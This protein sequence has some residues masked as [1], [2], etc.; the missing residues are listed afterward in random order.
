MNFS[1]YMEKY[2]YFVQN[3]TLVLNNYTNRVDVPDKYSIYFVE[4]AGKIIIDSFV[5]NYRITIEDLPT[6]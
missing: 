1:N 6:S 4:E 5:D 2:P 3:I